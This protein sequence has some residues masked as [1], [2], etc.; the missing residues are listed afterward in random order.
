MSDI[1]LH[2]GDFL[3]IIRSLK[4]NP[5]PSKGELN[6]HVS[7]LSSLFFSDFDLNS[8]KNLN[9]I[10]NNSDY[11]ILKLYYC[12]GCIY[13]RNK[14]PNLNLINE[15]NKLEF[16]ERVYRKL[17]DEIF[18]F[19][20]NPNS[21]SLE[22]INNFTISDDIK[23]LSYDIMF[24][25]ST[26]DINT[27]FDL[28]PDLVND[29]FEY[30]DDLL[31]LKN[32]D[33]YQSVIKDR[34]S[35]IIFFISKYYH[36]FSDND[37]FVCI[38]LLIDNKKFNILLLHLFIRLSFSYSY[39]FH[40]VLNYIN[41]FFVFL[42]KHSYYGISQ[43]SNLLAFLNSEFDPLLDWYE[44][45]L[46]K[47]N[48]T[49]NYLLEDDTHI[50][51]H[52]NYQV[53]SRFCL[54]AIYETASFRR[55]NMK[56]YN[57]KKSSPLINVIGGIHSLSWA[58]IGNNSFSTKL[59]LIYND[60]TNTDK[61]YIF[62]YDSL[63]KRL[64]SNSLYNIILLDPSF[65]NTNDVSLIFDNFITNISNIINSNNLYLIT[66]PT[67]ES[68]LYNNL[69]NF[70]FYNKKHK[71]IN[72]VIVNKKIDYDYNIIDINNY[73]KN[74]KLIVSDSLL[75]GY[76]I[77]PDIIFNIIESNILNNE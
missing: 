22:K 77:K 59:N 50:L 56:Y 37:L 30:K 33:T 53:N 69:L 65:F 21:V 5:S 75:N 52:V 63:A 11:D 48:K 74:N 36:K 35:F 43:Y 66:L 15:V 61:N 23:F 9:N 60:Y 32:M 68:S 27:T 29:V 62:H 72:N 46:D 12:L 4:S 58:N 40:S 3:E 28:F 42:P 73:I 7:S 41:N 38:K 45:L 8:F 31:Y 17:L 76:I 57:T 18:S 71:E 19:I 2:K 70:D 13:C 10:K 24:Y 49:I 47:N 34:G 51:S 55:D 26:I 54:D 1:Y 16:D 25:L 20:D 67:I 39:N 44:P 64:N 6:L 14:F